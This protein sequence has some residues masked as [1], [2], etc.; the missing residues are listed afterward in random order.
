LVELRITIVLVFII[1]ILFLI[2][3]KIEF[4]KSNN[5]INPKNPDSAFKSGSKIV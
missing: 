2:L 5:P 4:S 1:T 3:Y